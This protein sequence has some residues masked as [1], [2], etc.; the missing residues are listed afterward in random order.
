MRCVERKLIVFSGPPC[1]GKTTLAESLCAETGFTYLQMDEIRRRLIPDSDHR[2]EHREIA[3]RAMHFVAELLLGHGQSVVVDATY[4][5][6]RDRE[7]IAKIADRTRAALFFIQCAVPFEVAALR[8]RERKNQHPAVDL[9][10]Q[11]VMRLAREFP[12]SSAGLKLDTTQ[13][14]QSC[15][16][17]I[18]R[19]VFSQ[20]IEVKG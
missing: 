3:Y 15:L 14:I 7:E 2:R 6:R 13:E 17:Q 16:K 19:Y 10:E 1:S 18:K 4:R 8:F 20:E 9:T 12:Y 5:R 11:R